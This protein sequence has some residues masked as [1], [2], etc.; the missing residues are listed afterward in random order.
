MYVLR[1]W[2]CVERVYASFCVIDLLCPKHCVRNKMW[3]HSASNTKLVTLWEQKT[4]DVVETENTGRCCNTELV[5]RLN[6]ARAIFGAHYRCLT[7]AFVRD[8][9]RHPSIPHV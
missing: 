7:P 3:E 9:E 1:L 2:L 8:C 5:M 4:R 6:A